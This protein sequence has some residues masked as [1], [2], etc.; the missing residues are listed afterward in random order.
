M[1]LLAEVFRG[2]GLSWPMGVYAT[3]ASPQR[4]GLSWP[5]GIIPA[6]ELPWL[7]APPQ[8]VGLSCLGITPIRRP[9]IPHPNFV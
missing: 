1:V 2:A 5:V 8:P 9:Y 6:V 7:L 4:L 3:L